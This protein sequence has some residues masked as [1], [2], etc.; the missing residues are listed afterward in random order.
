M[1]D[2]SSH[3]IHPKL[4]LTQTGDTDRKAVCVVSF[5]SDVRLCLLHILQEL[6]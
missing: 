3:S 2:G 5:C 6:E 4:T 1:R